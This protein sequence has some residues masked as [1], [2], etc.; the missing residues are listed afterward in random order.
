VRQAHAR[1]ASVLVEVHGHHTQQIDI[2]RTVDLV[3][4]F[5]LP[6]L[7][8][9]ALTA[10]DL[11]PLDHWLRIRPANAVTVLDTHDG[12]GIVDVGLSDLRPGEPGLLEPDQIHALVEAIHAN[13]DGT[14][15]LATG[16]AA[17]NL[18]LYQVNCTF[19]DALGRDDRRYVLARLLQL[20]VPGIPQVYYVGL[21]AGTND[22]ELLERS[23]VGRDVNRRHYSADEVERDLAR[24]AVQAQLEAL[25]VRSAHGAFAGTFSWEIEGTRARLV[26]TS[27]DER[28]GLELDVADASFSMT[29]TSHAGPVEVLSGRDLADRGPG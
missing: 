5:A 29:V 9:H 20:F 4:D 21:L 28:A 26:W 22:M 18:D 19:Y 1:G 17:S 24:P 2:A 10:R 23:G 12:I 13:S 3:Y 15:R 6:P 7:V 27:G 14:S 11:A 25:R 8:L 16:A